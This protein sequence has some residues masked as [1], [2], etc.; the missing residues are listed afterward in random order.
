VGKDW[1]SLKNLRSSFIWEI[2]TLIIS[3]KK[4]DNRL[5]HMALLSLS[6]LGIIMVVGIFDLWLAMAVGAA[7]VPFILITDA[8]F[9][10]IVT[11][12]FLKPILDV[13]QA[14]RGAVQ[15][16]AKG[17]LERT[18]RWNFA[19]LIL[20][21]VSSTALY[22]HV[23]V[24]YLLSVL[25]RYSHLHSSVVGNPH[26]FGIPMVS[27]LNILGMVLLCGMFKDTVL[28]SRHASSSKLRV[29][30]SA[31]GEQRKELGFIIDSHAYSKQAA[32][33]EESS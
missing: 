13:L 30:P 20:T 14:A 27:M 25:Y 23:I 18:K 2:R 22:L 32:I 10:V 8:I 26:V 16:A 31:L 28:S 11:F 19:G 4:K 12:I 9:S 15:T 7:I 24:F 1:L 33:P 6:L 5:C 3:G 17:R 29:R 21:V